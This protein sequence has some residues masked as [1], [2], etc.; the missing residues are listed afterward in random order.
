MRSSASGLDVR[1]LSVP[2][3]FRRCA[4][5]SST[6]GHL[7]LARHLMVRQ[8]QSRE[9]D[10][11]HQHTFEVVE[12]HLACDAVAQVLTG[13]QTARVTAQDTEG[14]EQSQAYHGWRA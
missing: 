4:V 2:I 7:C 10:H 13:D 5:G 9:G 12:L 11:R 6:E 14:R 3:P 1:F 8:G